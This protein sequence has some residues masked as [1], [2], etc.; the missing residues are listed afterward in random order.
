MA[1]MIGYLS[2]L[3]NR[4][5]YVQS[6]HGSTKTFSDLLLPNAFYLNRHRVAQGLADTL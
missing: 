6:L 1:L 2:L 3:E 4:R 5:N